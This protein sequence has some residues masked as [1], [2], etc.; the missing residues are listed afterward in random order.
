M[1]FLLTAV[2]AQHTSVRSE[3]RRGEDPEYPESSEDPEDVGDPGDPE[4]EAQRTTRRR[5]R[6]IPT[7]FSSGSQPVTGVEFTQDTS[8]TCH[9]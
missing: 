4:G 3:T 8:I 5:S 6:I 7:D 1:V 9:H 2:M